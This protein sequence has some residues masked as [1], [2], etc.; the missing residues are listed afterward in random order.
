ME[1]DV[2][3]KRL[4]QSVFGHLIRRG[5]LQ[6]T[7]PDRTH[8]V[9]AGA[10]GPSAEIAITDS[11]SLR[12]L[13]LNP[14]LALGEAYMDGGLQPADGDIYAVLD[15]LLTNINAGGTH[16]MLRLHQRLRAATRSRR[17]ANDASRARRNVAHHYDLDKDFY[18]LFLD[19]DLQY[20]CAFFPH[21]DETLEQAQLA[22]K[23][24]IASK[25]YLTRR[26][27][28]VLDI[29]CGWGGLALTLAQ[30]YGAEVTGIT[31]STEQLAVARRRAEQAG[32]AGQVRFEL[33]DY[34]SL[35]TKYD[36]VVS[37]GMMEHVG[38]VNYDLFFQCVRRC[39]VDEGVSL[40]HHIVR[41]DGPG[42]TAAWLQ[43]YIFPGG[44]SPAFCEVMP[45]IERSGL[46][47][48]DVE[49]LRLHYAQTLRHWRNRFAA[50]RDDIR[51]MYDE[52]FCR[53]FEFYLAAAELAFRREREVVM[54]LQLSPSLTALPPS[55]DYLFDPQFG[56]HKTRQLIEA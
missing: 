52:R 45:S 4:L 33:A 37:V 40:I 9:F 1:G 36:R 50:R 19:E 32:L 43:K 39:L 48:T 13:A 23:H 38:V 49:T 53:M 44:Y 7:W 12:R 34:R 35:H 47:L 56:H 41:S 42:S 20:S 14:A 27:M 17:Q 18:R 46:L 10:D 29:G 31:L 8:S 30:D 3:T 5:R 16:P 2:V 22:K 54:Q 6:I 21:G 28:S 51:A 15:V 11:A 24:L 25:L 26:G 55:R